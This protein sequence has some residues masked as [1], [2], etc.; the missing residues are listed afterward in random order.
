MI[1]YLKI[2]TTRHAF[3]NKYHLLVSWD[4]MV[5]GREMVIDVDNNEINIPR[6]GVEDIYRLCDEFL[7]DKDFSHSYLTI[8]K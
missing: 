7:N 8:S 5:G 3:K 1:K 4:G 2:R 6:E